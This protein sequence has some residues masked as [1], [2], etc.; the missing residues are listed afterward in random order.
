MWKLS[1]KLTKMFTHPD[2]KSPLR[3]AITINSRLE[4]LKISLPCV[5]LLCNPGLKMRHWDLINKKIDVHITPDAATTLKVMLHHEKVIE[6]HL[7]DL[8]EIALLASKEYALEQAR[9]CTAINKISI[10]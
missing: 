8:N 5:Q 7:E 10:H 1:Y 3:A 4:K 9:F 2:C 6:K